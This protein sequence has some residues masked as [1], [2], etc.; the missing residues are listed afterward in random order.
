MLPIYARH[1]VAVGILAT[2]S[3]INALAEHASPIAV[4]CHGEA[5]KRYIADF[6]RIGASEKESEA[7]VSTK[8]VND[9]LK[10][11]DYYAE[12]IGRWN[13]MRVR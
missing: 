10:Y 5:T 13:S 8:F 9:K 2:T 12:C 3:S 6:R 11:E 7:V 4:E 1:I